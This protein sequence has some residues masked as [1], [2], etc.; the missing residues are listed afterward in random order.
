MRTPEE[1]CGDILGE[2]TPDVTGTSEAWAQGFVTEY[3]R[4]RDAAMRADERAKVMDAVR[5]AIDE[6]SYTSPHGAPDSVDVWDLLVELG[7][8]SEET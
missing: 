1:A 3:I 2:L 5:R 7:M 4:S 8:E 6:H